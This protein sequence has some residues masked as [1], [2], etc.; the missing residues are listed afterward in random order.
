MY[1]LQI[2]LF[3]LFFEKHKTFGDRKGMGALSYN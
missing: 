2:S 1:F 3:W